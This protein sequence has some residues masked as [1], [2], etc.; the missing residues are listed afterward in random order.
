[1]ELYFKIVDRFSSLRKLSFVSIHNK[2]NIDRDISEVSSMTDISKGRLAVPIQKH[3][4]NIK[5]VTGPGF[6]DN[7]DGV[8][9]NLKFDTI[10]SLSVADCVPVCMTDD[11]KGNFALVHSGWRGTKSKI[12]KNA[13]DVLIEKGSE[14]ENI[15]IYLGPSIS[16][17]NY[18]VDF[19]V[20]QYFSDSSYDFNGEK[21]L[22]DIRSQIIDDLVDIGIDESNITYSKRCTYDEYDLCSFRRDGVEAGRMIF[23][24]GDYN[25][26]V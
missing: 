19:D 5:W 21:Y 24:L 20:A 18:E 10:L 11:I 13:V 8:A 16:K 4:N 22:L 12:S 15:K 1:M 25:V 9:T 6:Y 2:G 26:R 14:I 3:T 17:K 7:F 23:L